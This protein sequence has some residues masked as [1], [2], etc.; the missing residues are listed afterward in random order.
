MSICERACAKRSPSSP[1]A[2]ELPREEAARFLQSCYESLQP[3]DECF[4]WD[5]WQ[6][7]IARLGLTELKPAGPTGFR[8]WLHRYVMAG[9]QGFSSRI[10]NMPS[11]ANYRRGGWRM[12]MNRFGRY[13]R[14]TVEL[15]R[16]RAE[17]Q[18][19]HANRGPFGGPEPTT[20]A[21]QS[22]QGRR[23]KRT[24]VHG[25]QAARNSRSAV[26]TR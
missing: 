3:Q 14:R 7:A 18:A 22:V 23:A 19:K 1:C 9:V 17:T 21:N 6:A 16:I 13:H 24:L 12:T 10:C 2:G 15:G 26:S 5:G 20:P 8:A 11:T 25:G 4:V